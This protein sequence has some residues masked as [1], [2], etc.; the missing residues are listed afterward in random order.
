V[1]ENN[2]FISGVKDSTTPVTGIWIVEDAQSLIDSIKSGSWVDATI[3]AITTGLDALSTAMDP[4]GALASMA[5]GWLME[6]VKPLKEALDK[7][8]GNADKVNSYAS[9]WHNVSEGLKQA[10]ADLKKAVAKDTPHWEGKS[11]KAYGSHSDY[12]VDAVAGLGVAAEVLSEAT[13]GAG[14]L[15]ATVRGIVRDLIAD[16]VST[17]LVRVPEWLAEEGFTLGLATPWVV[18]QVTSLVAKWVAR[19][20]GFTTALVTSLQALQLL[21]G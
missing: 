4:L 7:L 16:C 19:I 6:H 3:G 10:G 17:L 1:G 20:T 21:L 12:T 5:I 15:V 14:E 8:T 9:T 11:A 2:P 18:G 13:K